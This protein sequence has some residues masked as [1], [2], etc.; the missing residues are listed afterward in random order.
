MAAV[1]PLVGIA[2]VAYVTYKALTA[3]YG[4]AKK[5]VTV[6]PLHYSNDFKDLQSDIQEA[7]SKPLSL[8][9]TTL[10]GGIYRVQ[11]NNPSHFYEINSEGLA[12][13]KMKP[14]ITIV[15]K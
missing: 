7:D 13:L 4:P 10:E 12:S 1:F 11:H 14:N 15:M 3:K 6:N 2:T 9:I 8:T 5:D